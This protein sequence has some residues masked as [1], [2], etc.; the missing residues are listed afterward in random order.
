[1]TADVGVVER[2]LRAVASHDW[3]TLRASV[4]PDVVRTGPFG[5]VYSGRDDYV[6]FLAELMPALPGY[7]MDIARVTYVDDG[8]RA[9]AELAETVTINGAPTVTPEVLTFAIDDD[10]LISQVTIYTRREV[11]AQ[12]SD[13]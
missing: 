13:I 6:H 9:F 12:V 8:R 2:Y 11:P 3:D 1:M 5:D 7:S 4:T 10:G